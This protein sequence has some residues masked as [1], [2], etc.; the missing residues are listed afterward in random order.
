MGKGQRRGTTCTGDLERL[1]LDVSQLNQKMF[2]KKN[3]ADQENREKRN[4][5]SL[6]NPSTQPYQ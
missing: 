4:K 2:L 6:S 5:H 1:L 3:K